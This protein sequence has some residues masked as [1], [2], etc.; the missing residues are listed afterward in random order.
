[1]TEGISATCYGVAVGVTD[2]TGS[3]IPARLREVLAPEFETS[4]GPVAVA[5]RVVDDPGGAPGTRQT[6]VRDGATA[7]EATDTD[8]VFAWLCQD[9]ENT[10]ARTSHEKLFVHAGVVGWRGV[11]IVVLGRSFAGKSTLVAEL[12]R[13]GAVYF[14]DEF[15]VL[16]DEGLVHPYRRPLVLRGETEACPNLRLLRNP[17]EPPLPI[18]LIVAG[19][20][21]PGSAWRPIVQRGARATLPLID[22]CVRGR[23][24]SARLLRIAARVTPNLVT[25]QGPR[26]DASDV[27]AELLDLVDD[28]LTSHAMGQDLPGGARFADD[29]AR[30]AETRLKS[31]AGRPAPT[32][33]R[34]DAPRYLRM[35]NF[36]SAA[37]RQR[38]FELVRAHEKDFADSGIVGSDGKIGVV[39]YGIR[40]SST[41]QNVHLD[42][43]WAM[44]DR[45]LRGV[46]PMVRRE[47]GVPWFAPGDV[48][49][50]ITRHGHDGF[51]V[52]H[53]DNGSVAT[54]NR[55]I[56][57]VYHF[58]AT[59]ARF[60]GGELK[61]YDT[62]VTPSGT[63]GAPSG[64]TLHPIDNSMIFL[65]ANI[66]HE[67]CNVHPIGD[68]AF[69]D[70]RFAVTIWYNAGTK[71][72]RL[73]AL[74]S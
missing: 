24:E 9:I 8:R 6:V 47:L 11:A 53:V 60:T 55:K 22:G 20:Y 39:D 72:E 57:C 19:S 12:V 50:Q 36:L 73:S 44:F 23:E 63:T 48:E 34:L 52:P 66:F 56:S 49:R 30:I 69:A 45:R 65:P 32:P 51:F 59:P 25:L 35:T 74:P 28:A 33:R 37:E 4:N 29:L 3:G 38:L 13:R 40:R 17:H 2:D 1:M 41:L 5:Y 27:A 26:P 21:Q 46:L 18:G 71:P 61:L 42:E 68:D 58:F 54:G 43:V 70:G 14:S 62:W 67:V 16:D 64:T 15:A 7:L 31:R 10:V